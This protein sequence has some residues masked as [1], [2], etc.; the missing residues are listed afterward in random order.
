MLAAMLNGVIVDQDKPVIYLDDRG[1]SYGDGVFETMLLRN[2][3]V[4]FLDDHIQ[5]IQQS[6]ERLNIFLPNSTWLHDEL[7]R[8]LNAHQDGIVKLLITRGRGSRGY[9]ASVDNKPTRLWQLF[10]PITSTNTGITVRWCT[11]RF[12][13]N[14]LLAGIKHL[15]RLEQVMARLEWHDEQVQEGL[16]LD[17]EGELI[18]ATMGNIFFVKDEKLIT[19]DLRFCGVHGIMRRNVL[20]FANEMKLPVE[21]RAV[22]PNELFV[23]TEVFVTNAVRG[24]QP[25]TKLVSADGD[26]Q[27]KIGEVTKRMM[28][29]L[30]DAT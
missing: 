16:M 10:A 20:R 7:Q 6:C 21:E 19:P 28:Q 26:R 4:R 24:I 29:R 15:N 2:G 5:R 13:R 11:T 17:T 22:M 18:S 8:L 14:S 3:Q 9:R 1:L 12:A 25:V 23:M 30:D 27:W